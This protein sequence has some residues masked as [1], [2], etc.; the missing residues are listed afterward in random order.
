MVE[1]A[2][3]AT[4]EDS[5]RV[6]RGGH[7]VRA[8]ATAVGADAGGRRRGSLLSDSTAAMATG[9]QCQLTSDFQYV[10]TSLEEADG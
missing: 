1:G 6:D 5:N 9:R 8:S 7:W 10:C 2:A 4:Q 3:A